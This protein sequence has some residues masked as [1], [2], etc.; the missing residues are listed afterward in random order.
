MTVLRFLVILAILLVLLVTVAVIAGGCYYANALKEDALSVHHGPDELDMRVVAVG[1]GRVTLEPAGADEDDD[2]TQA[3]VFGL[4]WEGGYGQVGAILEISHEK[5][6]REF[7]TL[8]G[9]VEA[10]TLARLDSFAFAGDPLSAFGLAY[11]DVVYTSPIGEFPAW[12]IPGDAKVWAIFVHG[13]GADRQEALRL[14]P[15]VADLGLPA[16]VITYRNDDNVPQ[17]GSY[18]Y[19]ETERQDLHAAVDYAL[20]EGAERVVLVGYS[21][22][23]AIVLNFLYQSALTD[24]VSALVLDSPLLDL[25]A[26]VDWGT[27][28]RFVPWPVADIGKAI[29]SVRY[30]IEWDDLDA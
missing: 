28:D 25:E 26:A 5:V 22:G 6:V 30:D 4:E 15:V 9:M 12:L 21:M 24:R 17:D 13:K 20:Q 29:A 27:R 1:D 7:V 10:G 18:G 14:L 2:W 11:R 8:D 3:G 16:L 19:G 23:G